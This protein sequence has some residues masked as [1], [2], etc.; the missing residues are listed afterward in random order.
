MKRAQKPEGKL[1]LKMRLGTGV[2]R[3]RIRTL[4]HGGEVCVLLIGLL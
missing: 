1:S 2:I 3:I 4:I